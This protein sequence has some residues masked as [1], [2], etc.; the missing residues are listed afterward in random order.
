MEVAVVEIKELGNVVLFEE[1]LAEL[2][3]AANAG[4]QSAKLYRSIGH[5][6]FELRRF[7]AAAHAYEEALRLATRYRHSGIIRPFITATPGASQ[8]R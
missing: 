6:H 8:A 4:H 5:L 7:G 1:A 2:R 3:A